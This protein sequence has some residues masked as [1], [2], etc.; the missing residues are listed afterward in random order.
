MCTPYIVI[1]LECGQDVIRLAHRCVERIIE[2][3]QQ[4]TALCCA[5]YG[6]VGVRIIDAAIEECQE[7]DDK[8]ICAGHE[9]T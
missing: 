4:A 5:K 2:E 9:V 1:Q 8:P 3:Q 6:G 7:G